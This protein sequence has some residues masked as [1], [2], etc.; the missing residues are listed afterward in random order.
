[1]GRYQVTPSACPGR[2]AIAINETLFAVGHSASLARCP[3]VGRGMDGERF[4]AL[5]L[6]LGLYA[7]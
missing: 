3:A 7:G 6:C 5:N 2:I 1:M 4:H